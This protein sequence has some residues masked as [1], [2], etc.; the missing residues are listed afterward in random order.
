M[1][2][3]GPS[4]SREVTRP[5]AWSRSFALVLVTRGLATV[6]TFLTIAL[7]GRS[8]GRI[9]YGELVVYLTLLKVAS[10]LIGP[11][12]DT[13]AVRF[14]ARCAD[15]RDA[16][17]YFRAVLLAKLSLGLAFI[18]L[19]V[20]GSGAIRQ[21]FLAEYPNGAWQFAAIV[22][23]S[24][25]AG[26]AM[27]QSFAQAALQAN[28]R[29]TAYAMT[30]FAGAAVR[31]VLVG[32]VLAS[33][34]NEPAL[35]LGAYAIAP[36]VVVAGAAPF[37]PRNALLPAIASRA[38]W[39]D[40]A[41]FSKWVLVACCCTSLA[42]RLDMLLIAHFREPPEAAGNYAAAVQLA[43]LGD[44]VIMTLFHVLLPRASRI[45]DAQAL[46]RFLRGFRV[47]SLLAF[48]GFI[49]AWM[50]SDWIIVAV[51]GREYAGAGP[52]FG[53]LLLGTVCAFASAPAGAALYGMGRPQVVAGLEALKAVLV[54][55]GGI[56]FVPSHGVVAMACVVAAA[57]ALVGSLTYFL[58]LRLAR[59]ATFQAG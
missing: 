8:L 39:R 5:P 29:F 43:L 53:L 4:E 7:L 35:I 52:M 31:L 47:P 11:A 1:N 56:S 25:G 22:L 34:Q 28:E 23:A 20:A 24:F 15:K 51:F 48:V 37:L 27:I 40:V 2:L 33:G 19:G 58:A 44:L 42:Q 12:L 10:E 49:P 55:L 26:T 46:A 18:A 3:G 14:A 21:W 6:L 50:L 59:S 41:A 38:V 36:L 16:A 9:A 45:Q 32:T 57:K 17:P 13:T 54:L 30:E